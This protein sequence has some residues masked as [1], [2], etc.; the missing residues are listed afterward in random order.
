MNNTLAIDLLETLTANATRRW[1]AERASAL[2][3]ALASTAETLALVAATT[4][5]LDD[6]EPDPGVPPAI[7]GSR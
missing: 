5:D 1:G 6:L 2:A 7:G 3:E 4:F